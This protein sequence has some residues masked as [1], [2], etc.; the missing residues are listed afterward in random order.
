MDR[1]RLIVVFCSV[2]DCDASQG[3]REI[4]VVP[5]TAA[6]LLYHLTF[7]VEQREGYRVRNSS[8][9]WHTRL[10]G[11]DVVDLIG[12][13]QLIKTQHLTTS[14]LPELVVD[15]VRQVVAQNERCCHVR[16]YQGNRGQT[17]NGDYEAST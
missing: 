8:Y 4:G 11:L 14:N 5:A 9:S 16:D 17:H 13:V 12:Q 6:E 2:G 10:T 7:R 15:P 3:V 1:P